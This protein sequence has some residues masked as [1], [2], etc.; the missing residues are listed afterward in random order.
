MEKHHPNESYFDRV[1]QYKMAV[2][3]QLDKPT[4]TPNIWGSALLNLTEYT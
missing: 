4:R 1:S 3:Q 2:E